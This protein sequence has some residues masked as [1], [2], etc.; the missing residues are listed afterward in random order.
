MDGRILLGVLVITFSCGCLD[1][2]GEDDMSDQRIGVVVSIPPMA[3][4]V[5]RVGGDRVR[6]SVM[7][8]P[9][10]TPHTYE[11]EASQ[12]REVGRAGMYVMVGSGIEFETVWM[13]RIVDVN[14]EMLV[15]NCS[16]GI[17]VVGGDP[18]VWLS[19]GNARVMVENIYQGLVQ[20]D[21]ESQE[22][23]ARNKEEYQEKLEEMD[24]WIRANLSGAEHKKIL[25]YHPAWAYFARDYG[26]EQV[27]IEEEGKEASP[28][29]VSDLISEVLAWNI[30]VIFASPHT[31]TRGAEMVAREIGG[32][33]VLVDPLAEKYLENMGNV[34]IAFKRS[35]GR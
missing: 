19:L 8:P 26:L 3:E 15:V 32:E 33:V 12:L 4:F 30:T 10:A 17:A 6:V 31:S 20:I 13:S 14:S 23:Y 28:K 5:E 35:V 9:G 7:V 27:A 29:R 25:V 18:H 16:D 34:A 11:P 2:P 24:A 22:Y 1:L 21:P